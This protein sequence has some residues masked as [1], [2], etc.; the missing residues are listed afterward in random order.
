MKSIN[1][2]LLAASLLLCMG[3]AMA[4]TPIDQ[5]RKLDAD[6]HVSIDNVKG[7]VT[8]T[9]WD[10]NQIRITGTL[11]DGAQ[12]LKVSGDSHDL[13][14]KVQGPS[15]SGW[16]S[17]GNDTHMGP[18]AL[19]IQVPSG[20]SLSVDVVSAEVSMSGLKGGRIDIDTVSGRVHV[21]AESP[22]VSVDSVSGNVQLD[23]TVKRADLETVSGD[24]LAPKVAR[25]AKVQTVSGDARVGGGPFEKVSLSTV[26]GD[27]QLD[28]GPDKDGD[29]DIDSMSGDVRLNLPA[30]TSA[31]MHAS[32]FSGALRSDVGQVSHSEH[33]PGSKL[34]TRIGN[35][36]ANI[37]V[38]TFSGNLRVRSG[39]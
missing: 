3:Q 28:G 23:G 35:G 14:I 8:V 26:S 21:D 39:Q 33:G 25:V 32:T 27:L 20:V 4:D 38:E 2:T 9:A 12:P 15:S 1:R 11:G 10:R 6:A 13:S 34:D 24:V 31:R 5:S 19:N 17:W 22:S 18:T 29:V 16:F 30:G 7:E 36:D 37:K